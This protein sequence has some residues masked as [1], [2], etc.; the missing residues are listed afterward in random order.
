MGKTAVTHVRITP[1]VKKEAETIIK[2]LGL[3]ISAAHEIF[4]RQIIAHQGIPFELR[5]LKR[6][7]IQA[8]DDA[9]NGVGKKYKD[10]NK[11]FEDFGV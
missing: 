11:M 1:E 8:M 5:I 4:Y 10:V 9:R 7:T 3:S 2:G 6:E